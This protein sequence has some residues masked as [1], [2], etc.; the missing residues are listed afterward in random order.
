V[1]SAH[2][3]RRFFG[4]LRPG[5]PQPGDVAWTESV[6]TPAE[7]ALWRRQ[8]D[9]DRRY[10]IR[11]ARRLEAELAGT[12]FACDHRWPAVAL[13]HDVG[14]LDSGLGVLGRSL[15]TVVGALV[16]PIRRSKGRFG[17][18]QRHGEIG[19]EMIRAAGGRAEAAQWAAAHH[20]RDR[21]A[22]T[23]IPAP[24]TAALDAAD[25]L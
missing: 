11:V 1:R 2:L 5:A 4:A 23:G 14:K 15:A 17:R 6:L 22:A 9:R 8:P 12:E 18:Y 10:S 3:V 7:C 19:A 21:W 24:V 13:L 16:P 25:N 20:H